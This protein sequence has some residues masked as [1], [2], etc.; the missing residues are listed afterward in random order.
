VDCAGED[1]IFC[2][3]FMFLDSVPERHILNKTNVV[4]LSTK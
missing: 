3:G 4:T 2:S 1:K